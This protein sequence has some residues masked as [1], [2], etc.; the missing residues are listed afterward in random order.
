[1]LSMFHTLDLLMYLIGILVLLLIWQFYK[2]QIAAGRILEVDIFD[3]SGVRMYLFATPNDEQTCKACSTINGRVFSPSLIA[4][5]DFT[6][7]EAPCMKPTPC[8]GVLVG[9]YGAWLEVRSALDRLRSSRKQGHIQLSGQEFR[10]SIDGPW[11]RTVG[12][13]TDRLSM[14]MLSAMTYKNSKQ[15]VAIGN[16]RYLIE[17]AKAIQHLMLLVPAFLRITQLLVRAEKW[18]EALNLIE[19]FEARFPNSESGLHFPSSKQREL[20]RITKTQ[21]F[22]NQLMKLSA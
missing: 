18:A 16:Y 9:L 13:E 21:A 8:T 22:K 3:R 15:G 11:E 20:M 7:L 12:A 1:M 4:K 19:L 17:H 2:M 6:P 10:E 5:S 14:Y